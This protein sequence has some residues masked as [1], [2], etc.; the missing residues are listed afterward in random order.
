MTSRRGCQSPSLGFTLPPRTTNLPPY[1]STV[2]VIGERGTV[3]QRRVVSVLRELDEKRTDEFDDDRAALSY[4]YDR[5]GS[6]LNDEEIAER[7][8]VQKKR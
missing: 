1:C 3:A 5:W 6:V 4:F 2:A 7:L 8:Q